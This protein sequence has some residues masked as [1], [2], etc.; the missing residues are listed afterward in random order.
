MVEL[1]VG[2]TAVGLVVSDGL[3]HGA[4]LVQLV[5]ELADMLLVRIA[6]G[7][8]GA[9][10]RRLAPQHVPLFHQPTHPLPAICVFRETG[11]N[12]YEFPI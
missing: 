8:R 7:G 9:V 1:P 4:G 11:K 3:F 10:L 6:V 5:L 2:G 12:S